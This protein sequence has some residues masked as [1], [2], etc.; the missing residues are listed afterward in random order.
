MVKAFSTSPSPSSLTLSQRPLSRPDLAE[1]LL[2][3]HGAGFEAA[4]EIADVDGADD[5]AE[6]EVV[7][8]ALGKTAVKGHLAAFETDAGA[9]AGAGFLALVAFAGG[10]AVAGAFAAAETLDAALGTRD[11]G[12]SREVA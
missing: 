7:E 11:W 2:V 6:V 10:L 4:V 8:A 12:C 1:R 9:A 3:D 5:I